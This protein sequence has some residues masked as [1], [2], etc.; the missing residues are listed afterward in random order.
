METNKGKKEKLIKSGEGK[1]CKDQGK[2][3]TEMGTQNQVN[4]KQKF[5]ENINN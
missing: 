4:L 5:Q 2:F 1:P 3:W